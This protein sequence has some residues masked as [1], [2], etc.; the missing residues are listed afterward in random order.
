MADPRETNTMPENPLS[1]PIPVPGEDRNTVNRAGL[2]TQLR[3]HI[4]TGL[5]F[6]PTISK[7]VLDEINIIRAKYGLEEF[8]LSDNDINSFQNMGITDE[9]RTELLDDLLKREIASSNHTPEEIG[10]FEEIREIVESSK[11][12]PPPAETSSGE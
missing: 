5:M 12:N 1:K 7:E 8:R 11:P 10:T 4:I 6:T 3:L 9:E 2:K